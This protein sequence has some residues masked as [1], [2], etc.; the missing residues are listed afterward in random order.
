M[1]RTRRRRFLLAA[2][3]LAAAPFAR[4]QARLPR[5]ALL[6]PNPVVT[7]SNDSRVYMA[8]WLAEL[9]WAPGRNVLVEHYS[10]D[11]REDRLAALADA[12]VREGADVIWVAGPEAALAA[13]R[14]TRTIPI[15]FYGVGRPVEQ[16]LV[17]SFAEPGRNVT[18]VAVIAGLEWG[19]CLEALR[20]IVPAARRLSWIRVLTVMRTV[21]GGELR[22]TDETVDPHAASLGFEIRRHGVSAPGDLDDGFDAMRAARPDAVACDFTAMTYRERHRIV[23]FANHHRLPSAFGALPYVEAGGLLSY[24]ASR[25]WM[26]KHSFTFVDRM[27]RGARPADLPVERPTRFELSINMKTAKALGLS[28]PQSLLLRAD[29]VFE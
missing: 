2:G 23:D 7:G 6:Y 10:A 14:A 3:A 18:G 11:G 25:V 26:A 15:A 17:D 13:A 4:A 8:K 12:I 29:R 20:E 28:V 1:Q 21:S 22:V 19:K 24:G 27:L 5:L 16:G 9:G